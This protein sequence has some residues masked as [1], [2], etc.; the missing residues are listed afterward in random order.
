MLKPRDRPEKLL[1][2]FLLGVVCGTFLAC[3]LILLNMSVTCMKTLTLTNMQMD[4]AIKGIF[5]SHTIFPSFWYSGNIAELIIRES[6]V[7]NP[8]LAIYVM[9]DIISHAFTFFAQLRLISTKLWLNWRSQ[10][11]K[12]IPSVLC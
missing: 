9:C 8:R 6:L 5:F 3:I 4:A 11:V 1:P 7:R 12:I 10:H 2:L